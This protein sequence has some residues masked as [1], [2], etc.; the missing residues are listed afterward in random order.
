MEKKTETL[1]T[2]YEV[3]HEIIS[4]ALDPNGAGNCRYCHW[5]TPEHQDWCPLAVI[6]RFTDA[7]LRT[8]KGVDL[9][10]E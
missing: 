6:N 10:D 3:L 4:N 5:R 9:D 1:P 7:H 2:P 8:I